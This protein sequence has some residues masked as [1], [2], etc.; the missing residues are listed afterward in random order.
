M[1]RFSAVLACGLLAGCASVPP[2][3]PA[4]RDQVRD[5]ALEARF[6]LRVSLPDRAAESSG[7]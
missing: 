3:P 2:E 6:A 7:G 4:S 5:F 1:L